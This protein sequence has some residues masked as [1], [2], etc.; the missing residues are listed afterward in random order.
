[1]NRLIRVGD[2]FESKM[3]ERL[4][5][6]RILRANENLAGRIFFLDVQSNFNYYVHH[7][8]LMTPEISYLPSHM[9]RIGEYEST[10]LGKLN[11]P[12]QPVI[13]IVGDMGSGKSTTISFI[14]YLLKQK[15]C[16]TCQSKSRITGCDNLI[17][18]IDFRKVTEDIRKSHD[19]S[20]LT[21]I[22][23]NDL[24]ARAS[25]ILDDEEELFEFWDFIII[26]FK[27]Q[28][29]QEG[30]EVI[31][32]MIREARWL[33]NSDEDRRTYTRRQELLGLLSDRDSNWHLRYLILLWRYLLQTRYNNHRDCVLII[34]DNVDTLEPVLQRKLVDL[35]LRTSNQDGPTFVILMRPETLMRQGLA[36]SLV[37]IVPHVGLSPLDVIRDRLQRFRDNQS[38]YLTPELGLTKDQRQI[39]SRYLLRMINDIQNDSGNAFVQFLSNASGNSVRLALILAQGLLMLRVDDMKKKSLTAHFLIRACIT[40]GQQQFR[41]SPKS[42]VNNPFDVNGIEIGR[43]LIKTRILQYLADQNSKC[44]LSKLRSIFIMFGFNEDS[45][46]RAI[47]EMLRIECQMIRSDGYD[48]FR[49]EWGDEQETLYLTAIGK[50]YINQL[51]YSTDFIQEVMLDCR[52]D[53]KEWPKLY[54]TGL[55]SEKLHYLY[56]FIRD[57][58]KEDERET[59]KFVRRLGP[60]KYHN[61]FGKHLITIDFVQRIYQSVWRIACSV[62]TKY[63]QHREEYSKLMADFTSLVRIQESKS[64]KLLGIQPRIV[65]TL[66]IYN[67]S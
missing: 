58:C 5:G 3:S 19:V 31:R 61:L 63:P 30:D 51:I 42:V 39:V 55:L 2:L 65:K 49:A 1:M 29:D 26:K 57:I 60:E 38:S 23:C 7:R 33:I 6:R 4:G 27:E 37:D 44:S 67:C 17:A 54:E 64:E 56:L 21:E 62:T 45:I 13:C 9:T 20:K 22:I 46:K 18:R 10:L 53:E 66:T 41:S 11:D 24:R 43:F 16:A 36:D 48:I 28:M 59:A 52:V 34:L 40:H 47:N 25:F 8:P 50:G 15:A 35:L 14:T 12:P 32:V